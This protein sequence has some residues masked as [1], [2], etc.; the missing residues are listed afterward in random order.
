MSYFRFID[1]NVDITKILEQVRQYDGDWNF[2]STMSNIAGKMNPYGFMPICI[3]TVPYEGANPKDS[4]TH[5]RTPMYY[6]HTELRKFLKK[7][8][9]HGHSRA[10]FF[11]LPVGGGVGRHIDDG[12]Y[13]LTRDRYHLSLQGRYEYTV[14]DETH[15]IEPGTFFW[16]DNKVHHGSVNIDT[17]ERITFV[18]DVPKSKRN[19]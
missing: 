16:F 6:K 19:P 5:E 3:A 18:F 13:Y 4:N 8:K 7:W 11:K 2:V 14:G 17:V 15:V 9:V 12:S 1:M 10:A